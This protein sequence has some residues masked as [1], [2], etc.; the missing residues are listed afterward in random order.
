MKKKQHT[1]ADI[2]HIAADKYLVSNS[3]YEADHI[4]ERFSCCA[5]SNAIFD[6][7]GNFY[8][9]DSGILSD[10]IMKGLNN[11]G[12]KVGSHT[13]FEKYG[14]QPDVYESVNPDVQGMRYMWLK[15]AALMAEEQ[16]I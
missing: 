4:K 9:F 15:W 1:I 13:L 3:R 16:G 12:C 2:L 5:I 14:D 10:Q 8:G 6:I 11:M 7:T